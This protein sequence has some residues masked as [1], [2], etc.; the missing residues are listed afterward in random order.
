MTSAKRSE[1]ETIISLTEDESTASVYS[2]ERRWWRRAERVG[3][4]LHGAGRDAKGREVWRD[5]TVDRRCVR[6]ARLRQGRRA[7][8]DA[9]KAALRRG[10]LRRPGGEVSEVGSQPVDN[11]GSGVSRE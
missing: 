7:V 9:Q 6:I 5:Y 4:K 1:R 10:N 3:G 2:T 8:T 11:G